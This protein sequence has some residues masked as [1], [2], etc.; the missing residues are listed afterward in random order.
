MTVEITLLIWIVILLAGILILNCIRL[1]LAM[2]QR[3]KIDAR[4]KIDKEEYARHR[5]MMVGMFKWF[6]RFIDRLG[7]AEDAKNTDRGD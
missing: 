1:R 3:S 6:Q 2:E 7:E 4:I 5:K